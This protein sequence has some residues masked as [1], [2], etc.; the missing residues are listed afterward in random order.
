[1]TDTDA[2]KAIFITGGA[3]GMGL[4]TGKLFSDRGWLVG[5]YDID[6]ATLTAAAADLDPDRTVLRRVDVTDEADFEAAMGEFGE[7]SGGRLDV[8]FNNAG[9]APGAWFDEMPM[10]TIRSIIDI[11]VFGVIIGT[12]AALPLLKATP[13]SINVSTSSSVARLPSGPA[14]SS[15]SESPSSSLSRSYTSVPRATS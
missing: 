12:R 13:G 4:A 9:I 7:R 3:G 5:L 15:K 6:E 2:R 8:M 11:N 1:M 10:D 14:A